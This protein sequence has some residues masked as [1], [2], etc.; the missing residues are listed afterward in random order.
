MAASLANNIYADPKTFLEML[1][2]CAQF[3]ERARHDV[4][5][6]KED[7]LDSMENRLSMLVGKMVSHPASTVFHVP[8]PPT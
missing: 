8:L 4:T 1:V 7:V 3:I 5:S 6:T 2:E